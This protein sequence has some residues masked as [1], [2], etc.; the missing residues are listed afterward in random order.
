[1]IYRNIKQILYSVYDYFFCSTSL[2]L[3]RTL[4]VFEI[5]RETSCTDIGS[6]PL[7][8]VWYRLLKKRETTLFCFILHKI[9]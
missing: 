3:L 8:L 4:N 1:M 7:V 6:S 2:V 9:Q 5:I